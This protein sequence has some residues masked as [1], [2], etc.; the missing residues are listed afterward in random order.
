MAAIMELY[1]PSLERTSS[2]ETESLGEASTQQRSDLPAPCEEQ[3][4][5]K[6]D[7]DPE[8]T[9]E[10]EDASAADFLCQLAEQPNARLSRG[11]AKVRRRE[12]ESA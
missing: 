12:S 4:P 3:E 6:P 7:E 8:E 9:D 5:G 2:E 1:A 11:R 10:E